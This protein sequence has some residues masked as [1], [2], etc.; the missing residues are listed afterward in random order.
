[1]GYSD[2][3]FN[4]RKV[5]GGWN[6]YPD[7]VTTDDLVIYPNV[8]DVSSALKLFGG[9]SLY[10]CGNSAS[11]IEFCIENFVSFGKVSY[12]GGDCKIASSIANKN[13]YIAPDGS[14]YVKIGGTSGTYVAGAATDSTGYMPFKDSGGTVRKLMVQA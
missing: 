5:A 2:P 3:H 6:I 12:D 11:A 10:L 4:V 8:T 7:G 14:G 1:M 13:I 9:G